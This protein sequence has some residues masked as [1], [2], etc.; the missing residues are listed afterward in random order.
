MT[1]APLIFLGAGAS[2]PFDI[3]PMKKMVNLFEEE[4]TNKGIDNQIDLWKDAKSKLEN[5]Y[6]VGNVDIEHMLTFFHFPYIDPASLTP[7]VIY[8]YK[9]A[10]KDPIL[11]VD[12]ETANS[13]VDALKTF[14]Y[15]CCNIQKHENIFPTYSTFWKVL[16]ELVGPKI[17]DFYTWSNLRVFT[18]NY[19]RCFEIFYNIARN[20]IRSPREII[21]GVG[22]EGRYYNYDYYIERDRDRPK[23]YKLH[24]SI[25]R[26]ITKAG[27]VRLC[28]RLMKKSDSIDGDEVV[29]EWMIWPLMGKYIYQ[30]PYSELM[31][32]FRE[33]LFERKTWLFV[34]FSFR[35]E[36]VNMILKDVNDRLEDKERRGQNLEKKTL[37]LIDRSA[38]EKKHLF[39]K[40]GM[41]Q[42][43][44]IDG[45]FGKKETFDKL[46]ENAQA[47]SL[48]K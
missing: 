28:E 31:D 43:W 47:H 46:R 22:E 3:P 15:N 8:H 6:G 17:P 19:D 24:G 30:Y 20:Q 32:Q 4:L 9:I 2:A 7:T 5:V 27:K 36:G 34:G 10:V 11:V 40:Y 25:Q 21:L 29:E 35:D 14:I 1:D 44:P 41:I 23:L 38:E 26:Y 37:I 12:V 18:T 16:S 48:F 39:E 45:E 42:F 33:T 13:I